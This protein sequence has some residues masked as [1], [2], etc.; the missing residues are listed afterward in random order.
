MRCSDSEVKEE[1][2]LEYINQLLMTGEVTGLFPKDELD[3]LINDIRPIYKAECPGESSIMSSN[4]ACTRVISPQLCRSSIAG[5]I[6]CQKGAET[7]QGGHR[8]L[9]S[10]QSW[11]CRLY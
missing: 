10:L 7:P 3:T 1:A 5:C 4:S 6:L 9:C 11:H 2:F 8:V